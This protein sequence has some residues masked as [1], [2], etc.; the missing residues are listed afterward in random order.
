V[1]SNR[2]VPEDLIRDL[3]Q[4]VEAARDG[5][6]STS[7]FA[8]Q[9][10]LVLARAAREVEGILK[11]RTQVPPHISDLAGHPT[12]GLQMELESH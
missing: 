12:F 10:D 4:C 3:I 2:F 9:C 7:L 5:V 6:D 1:T 8:M 11:P